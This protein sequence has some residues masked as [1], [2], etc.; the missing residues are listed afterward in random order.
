MPGVQTF[1]GLLDPAQK[2]GIVLQS[3][4]KL[5]F[6]RFKTDQHSGWLAVARDHDLLRFGLAEIPRQIVLDFGER[7]FFHSGF[8]NCASHESASSLVTIAKT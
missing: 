4:F 6:F 3:I 5:I 8:P 1:A 7:N 2:S